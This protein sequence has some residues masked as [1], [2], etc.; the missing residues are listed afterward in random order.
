M[1]RWYSALGV[2]GAA[3]AMLS[4]V[5]GSAQDSSGSVAAQGVVSDE[6]RQIYE[7]ICQACHMPGGIGGGEA[8][9]GA[10]FPAL[11]GNA[12]LADA[13]YTLKVVVKGQ[14]GMPWFDDML[15]PPQIAAVTNYVR[16]QYNSFPGEVTEADVAALMTGRNTPDSAECVSCE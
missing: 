1:T 3:A 6:G 7:Q 10:V 12:K 13:A 4:A 8:G 2:C 11:A 14:G 15:T 5:A 16:N 9:A